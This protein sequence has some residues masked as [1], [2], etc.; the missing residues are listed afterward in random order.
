[1][2]HMT[3]FN[4]IM[5]EAP[6]DILAGGGGGAPA[7]PAANVPP[8]AG[9]G[10]TPTFE[11]LKLPED[12]V[13]RHVPENMRAEPVLKNFNSF[14]GMVKSLIHSQKTMGA[15][16]V[17]IPNSNFTD[18]DWK[19][20]HAKIG[21]PETAEGYEFKKPEN[22]SFEDDF[23]KAYKENAHKLGLMPKQAEALSNWFSERTL[24]AQD[25]LDKQSTLQ[26]TE[27]VDGLKKEWGL[28]FDKKV[29]D[30]N[31][32]LTEFAN[33]EEMVF[34]KKAGLANEPHMVRL[35]SRAA[36]KTLGEDKL[37]GEGQGP[38]GI[39]PVEAQQKI[40]TY[41]QDMNSPY[42]NK[43]HPNHEVAVKEVQELHNQLAAGQ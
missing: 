2:Y 6:G 25:S 11:E 3:R 19:Q 17:A 12:W 22:V 21:V 28:A 4:L 15:D 33:E 1:M 38:V 5:E 13:T 14:E 37:K 31:L 24:E 7:V 34:I 40:N 20:F 41:M 39:T 27:A 29:A 26:K 32:F 35:F 10:T 9:E 30:A 42:F 23:F 18:E 36:E 43:T 16:K 8:V